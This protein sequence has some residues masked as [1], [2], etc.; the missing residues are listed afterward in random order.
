MVGILVVAAVIACN[1]LVLADDT[2]SPVTSAPVSASP[3][4]PPTDEPTMAPTIAATVK[5]KMMKKMKK[6]KVID[7]KKPPVKPK[8]MGA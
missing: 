1:T 4:I 3:V 5:V 6:K 2:G 8:M 7:G